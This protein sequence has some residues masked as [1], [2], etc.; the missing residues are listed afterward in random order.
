V[1]PKVFSGFFQFLYLDG[2][3]RLG[4]VQGLSGFG[5]AV[6]VRHGVKDVEMME[7]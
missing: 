7:V 6:M 5:K 1:T 4:D 3:R 2:H